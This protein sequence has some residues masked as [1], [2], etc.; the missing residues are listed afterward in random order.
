MH[1]CTHQLG[2]SDEW[3]NSQRNEIT[4]VTQEKIESL[5]NPTHIKL[6]KNFPTEKIADSDNFRILV[7]SNFKR[8]IKPKHTGYFRELEKT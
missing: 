5:K 4:K 2:N 8:T 7:L 1:R 3:T 6:V